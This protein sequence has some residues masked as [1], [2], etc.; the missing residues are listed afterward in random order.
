M[1]V[2]KASMAF[3]AV[4]VR[5]DNGKLLRASRP[6][7]PLASNQNC[8]A[9][10]KFNSNS[11]A[12]ISTSHPNQAIEA[13]EVSGRFFEVDVGAGVDELTRS[14]RRLHASSIKRTQS[15]SK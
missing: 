11:R 5:R 13:R 3:W 6:W 2:A 1:P 4:M 15:R 10:F 8:P 7:L 14:K 9:R 12:R